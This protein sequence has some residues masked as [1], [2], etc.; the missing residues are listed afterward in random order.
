MRLLVGPGCTRATPSRAPATWSSGP[1]RRS[2]TSNNE[3]HLRWFDHFLKGRPNGVERGA[4]GQDLRDGHGRRTQGH[5]T[6]GC[7]TAG[8]GGRRPPGRCRTRAHRATTST[9]TAALARQIPRPACRRPSTPTIRAIRCRRSAD[10]SRAREGW[11]SPGA[12]DQREREFKGDADNGLLGS[13]PPYLPLQGP[14]GCDRVSDRAAHGRHRGR[15]ARSWSIC[16]RRRR[17]WIPTSPPSWST[18]IHRARTSRRLRHEPHRRHHA[19][20]L[21]PLAG[22]A[23]ADEAGRSLRVRDRAVPDRERVQE[24]APHPRS[25]SRAATFRASTSI[26]TPA[27]RWA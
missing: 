9:P 24:G 17:R 7:I 26:R 10:R 13:K 23:G 8:P 12:F 16:S 20:A 2:P 15:R 27:N 1:T 5:R 11:W 21:S 4:A 18:S 19:R 3:F 6:G 14:A 25:T 22:E